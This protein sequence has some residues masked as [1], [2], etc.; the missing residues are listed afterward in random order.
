LIVFAQEM[1]RGV[2]EN[3]V[4]AHPPCRQ[5]QRR[6]IPN[7]TKGRGGLAPLTMG[8]PAPNLSAGAIRSQIV[9]VNSVLAH[10]CQD[11]LA[12]ANQL[13]GRSVF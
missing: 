3:C 9:H 10:Q 2:A 1:M 6:P 13:F 11:V 8:K 5:S 7:T 4:F 12:G